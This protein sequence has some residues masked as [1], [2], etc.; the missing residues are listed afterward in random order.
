[1]YDIFVKDLI[2][3]CDCKIL[4]GNIDTKVENCF[5]AS[6]GYHISLPSHLLETVK[7]ILTDDESCEQMNNSAAGLVIRPYEKDGETYYTADF[8]DVES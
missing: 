3:K 6:D 4:T 7:E 8:V 2:D 1:M 5:V